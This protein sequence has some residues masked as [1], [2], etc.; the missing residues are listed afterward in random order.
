MKWNSGYRTLFLLCVPHPS[1]PWHWV[2]LSKLSLGLVQPVHH[3][4]GSPT[5]SNTQSMNSEQCWHSKEITTVCPGKAHFKNLSVCLPSL[6]CLETVS[7]GQV[8]LYLLPYWCFDTINI[9]NN[10]FMPRKGYVGIKHKI[11]PCFPEAAGCV[12]IHPFKPS[13]QFLRH[14]Y[15]ELRSF[16]DQGHFSWVSSSRLCWW[17]GFFFWKLVLL[18]GAVW[19]GLSGHGSP[20]QQANIASA[21]VNS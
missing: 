7:T 18:Q 14:P 8:L 19:V 16:I 4:K 3:L 9:T 17:V 12:S 20:S 1:A 21:N 15:L 13:Q 5:N 10:I 2:F 11:H 6:F